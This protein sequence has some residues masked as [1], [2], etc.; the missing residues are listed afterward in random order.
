MSYTKT[1]I[2]GITALVVILLFSGCT[3][4]QEPSFE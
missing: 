1:L 2:F 3:Q 4:N